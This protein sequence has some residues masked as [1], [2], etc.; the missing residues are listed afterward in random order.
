MAHRVAHLSD[1][2]HFDRATLARLNSAVILGLIGSGLVACAAGA[3]V[4]DVGRLFAGW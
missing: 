2:A 1:K 3:V 4:F